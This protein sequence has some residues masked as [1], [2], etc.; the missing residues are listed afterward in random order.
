MTNQLYI[1]IKIDIDADIYLKFYY[2]HKNILI[3]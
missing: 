3:H 1:D 2:K